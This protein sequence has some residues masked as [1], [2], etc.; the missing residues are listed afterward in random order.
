MLGYAYFVFAH[1]K[2]REI[3]ALKL[4][5]RNTLDYSSKIEFKR[6]ERTLRHIFLNIIF[7][8]IIQGFF[9]LM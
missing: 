4:E 1:H 9:Y 3:I 5:R 6:L 7:N 8:L 2:A